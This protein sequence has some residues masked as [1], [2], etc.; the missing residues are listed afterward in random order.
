MLHLEKSKANIL[1][2]YVYVECTHEGLP[3]E[4]SQLSDLVHQEFLQ[5]IS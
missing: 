4:P 5:L 2:V 3:E 1:R